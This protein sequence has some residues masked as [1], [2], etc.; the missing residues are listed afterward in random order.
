MVK[1]ES[2][3]ELLKKLKVHSSSEQHEKAVEFAEKVLAHNADDKEAQ[4]AQII[5]LIKL[6]RF[7][8][9]VKVFERTPKLINDFAMEYAYSLYSIDDN[10]KAMDVINT[11]LNSKSISKFKQRGLLHLKAQIAYK[12]EDFETAEATYM[13]LESGSYDIEG[14]E[15]DI[16]V[17]KLAITALA[18]LSSPSE[19]TSISAPEPGSESSH[20]Q[21]FNIATAKIGEGKYSESLELLQRAR[22]LVNSS[23]GLSDDERASELAPILLQASFVHIVLNQPED[24]AIIMK[25]I[26]PDYTSPAMTTIATNNTVVLQAAENFSNPHKVLRS[27]DKVQSPS[28]APTAGLVRFQRRKLQRNRIILE[29]LVGKENAVKRAVKRHLSIFPDDYSVALLPALPT[30][31]DPFAAAGSKFSDKK[32]LQRLLASYRREPA[33]IA[34]GL[35]CIQ[36][37]LNQAK[38][39]YDYAAEIVDALLSNKSYPAL[40][41]LASYVYIRQGRRSRAATLLASYV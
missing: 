5:A 14:E 13:Q 12:E 2:L 32:I 30:V 38:P 23:D 33:N 34:L 27:F 4:K 17:N 40:V 19:D 36:L 16:M 10:K 25:I 26:D 8:D 20:E 9:C 37:L 35:A 11:G 24:A 7:K 15:H 6:E 29:H 41:A 28:Y 22:E 1:Q 21:I 31:T 18:K 39:N 3:E